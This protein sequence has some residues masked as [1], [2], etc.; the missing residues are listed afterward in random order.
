MQGGLTSVSSKSDF[1]MLPLFWYVLLP[2]MKV[3]LCRVFLFSFL[4]KAL[5]RLKHYDTF[6]TPEKYILLKQLYYLQFNNRTE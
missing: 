2:Y 3:T 6:I 1:F 5:Q 4:E